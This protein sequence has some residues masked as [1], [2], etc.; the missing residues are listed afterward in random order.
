MSV[1]PLLRRTRSLCYDST[2]SYETR[3]VTT[4]RPPLRGPWPVRALRVWGNA[5]ARTAPHSLLPRQDPAPGAACAEG[6]RTGAAPAA[7][8]AALHPGPLRQGAS[9]PLRP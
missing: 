5:G 6:L 8:G 4:G 3:T 7:A 2:Q 1:L 9:D